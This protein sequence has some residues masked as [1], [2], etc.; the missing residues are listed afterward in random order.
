MGCQKWLCL[1]AH[2]FL[3]Y[4]WRSRW[5]GCCISLLVATGFGCFLL[6]TFWVLQSEWTKWPILLI[7]GHGYYIVYTKYI[8][9]PIWSILFAKNY[10]VFYSSNKKPKTSIQISP[11]LLILAFSQILKSTRYKKLAPNA[12]RFTYQNLKS[13]KPHEQTKQKTSKC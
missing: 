9:L 10:L 1:C 12:L 5:C 3:T 6:M 11:S 4:F 8:Q 2:I 7:F 13:C